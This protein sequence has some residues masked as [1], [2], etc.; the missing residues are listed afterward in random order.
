MRVLFG[1]TIPAF[2][3]TPTGH[4]WHWV[5]N[6]E[7][8]TQ[9]ANANDI[10]VEWLA[11]LQHDSR[12]QEPFHELLDRLARLDDAGLQVTAW[13]FSIDTGEDQV[14]SA[15]RLAAICT[16][17]NLIIAHAL[18]SGHDWVYFADADISAPGNILEQLLELEWPV[19]GAHVP[20]YCLDGEPI[21]AIAHPAGRI[22]R[23]PEHAD[24]RL[25]WNTAG[26]LLVAREAF[27]K[28]PWR[29]DPDDGLTDDPATQH[30]LASWGLP[31]VVRHDVVCTHHPGA[32][33]PLEQRG[34]DLSVH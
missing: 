34:H 3:M 29:F 14:T 7:Q 2:K 15:N 22:V 19:V 28:V 11:V 33:G 27:R 10:D 13:W 23:F 16:G 30:Q 8:L 5:E 12:G 4:W 20:T 1:S 6:A 9:H 24:T 25:H 21:R 32:I 31:T 17:R 18:R 26:S